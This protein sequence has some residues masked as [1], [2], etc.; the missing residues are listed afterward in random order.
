M[1]LYL[2][3]FTMQIATQHLNMC[4]WIIVIDYRNWSYVPLPNVLMLL[5]KFYHFRHCTSGLP[6]DITVEI[7]ELSFHLHKVDF[8]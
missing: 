8:M 1:K 2:N 3:F 4:G 6:S 7:G 5:Y